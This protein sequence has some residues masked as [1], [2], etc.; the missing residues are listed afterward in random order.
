M[1]TERSH[2]TRLLSSWPVFPRGQHRAERSPGEVG[3]FGVQRWKSLSRSARPLPEGTYIHLEYEE[4]GVT[5]PREHIPSQTP[6]TPK[7]VSA[8]PSLSG[9]QRRG[10]RLGRESF[11]AAGFLRWW[12]GLSHG[13][14]QASAVVEPG[15]WEGGP[16]EQSL[17]GGQGRRQLGQQ[18]SP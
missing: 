8:L 1:G 17:P 12:G 4:N 11:L 18:P 15:R 6:L 2:G 14:P 16:S 5:C 9:N 7:P 3:R 13:D 10:P